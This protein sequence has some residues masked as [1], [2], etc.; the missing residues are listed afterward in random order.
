MW[1]S[2]VLD[3][4]EI[5]NKR[6]WFRAD[7]REGVTDGSSARAWTDVW[8]FLMHNEICSF[9]PLS[10]SSIDFAYVLGIT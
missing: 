9:P 1:Q 2:S 10:M 6:D 8:A 7:G 3:F 4:Q 5:G